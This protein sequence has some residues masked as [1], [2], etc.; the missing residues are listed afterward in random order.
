MYLFNPPNTTEGNQYLAGNEFVPGTLK[1]KGITYS[2]L[3]LNYD[4]YN[5]QLLLRY[6]S[7]TGALNRIIV[8]DAWIESFSMNNLNF[9][10]LKNN[11]RKMFYQVFGDG[12][13][14][15]LYHWTKKLELGHFLG[16][17]NRVFSKPHRA[18]YL[19]YD[20]TVLEYRNN[21]GLIALFDK[22]EGVKIRDYLQ[23]NKISLRKASDSRMAEL[24]SFVNAQA[25]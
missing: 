21:K 9:L 10:V 8:S 13:Y 20:D 14:R 2:G 17:T 1:L 7:N 6:K 22:S 23:R 16:A 4:I 3:Q 18:M 24:V 25:R 5:Q 12:K 15:L 11:G 19:F